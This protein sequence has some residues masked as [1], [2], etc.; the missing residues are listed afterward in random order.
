MLTV[1]FSM[2]LDYVFDTVNH[3][4]IRLI[5]TI[6]LRLTKKTADMYVTEISS[7]R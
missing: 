1:L 3:D 7:I 2:N 4:A 6:C 5:Q